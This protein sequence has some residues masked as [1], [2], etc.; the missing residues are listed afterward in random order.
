MLDNCMTNPGNANLSSRAIRVN[1]VDAA[2]SIGLFL[3]FWGHILYEG[4]D[5]AATLNKAI[6]SFHMPMYFLLSGYVLKSDTKTFLQFVKDKVFR[7]LIPALVLYILT[8]PLYFYFLDTPASPMSVIRTICYFD[9]QCAYN[10]PIWF[11]FSLFVILIVAKLLKLAQSGI[12]KLVA[13][14]A[15]T[16]LL[17]Y[18]C[19]ASQW[20]V[21]N[22][23]GFNKALL[24]LFFVSCGALLKH[25]PYSGRVGTVGLVALPLWVVS[26]LLL[27]TKVSIYGMELGN[28]WLFV[29]S[30]LSGSLC[31]FALCKLFDGSRFVR[32]YAR[33]T[34]FIVSSHMVLVTAFGFISQTL[35]FN[36]TI[37]FDVLSA[38]FVLVSLV[39]YR[40]LCKY[41]ERRFPFI[42]GIG[43]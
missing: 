8:L 40:Y 19:Y 20:Q 31:F 15:T 36:G 29:I 6:Y 4:S 7:I 33:W 9:G 26:G 17:S 30:S 27:N 3:V 10:S 39:V 37:L 41:L 11:F 32:E 25:I 24:G 16:L 42:L 5:L 38:A 18:M 21:F 2:K 22:T 13:V 34:I 1:W 14:I 23:F 28:F 12:A 43:R 35:S